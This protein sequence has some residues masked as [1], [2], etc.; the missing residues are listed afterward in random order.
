MLRLVSRGRF[1][2]ASIAGQRLGRRVQPNQERRCD[3]SANHAPGAIKPPSRRHWPKG[4]AILH[5]D[6]DILVVDKAS[7][8][9]TVSPD[10]P[11]ERT[12]HFLL[13]DYVRKGN[14]KSKNRVWIVH[15]LDKDTSGVLVF[16]K[17]EEAKR[18]LQDEWQSFT[19]T[20]YA[21]V[22]GVPA[23]KEGVVRSYLAENRVFVVYSVDNPADGKLAVT[24]YKVV[25][26]A[27]ERSLLEIELE[28]G[29]KNQIRVHC[30][31][32]GCPVVGDKKYGAR[33]AG[34]HRLALHAA[35]LTLVHPFTK[36]WMTFEAPLPD[37][38]RN[39]LRGRTG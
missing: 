16:A 18:F 39:L 1:D 9:L 35:R 5:E 14:P 17:S 11:S 30:A 25:R 7:R 12:A 28:T 24:R 19:K 37:D 2:S 23:N 32:M 27:S 13:N 15:R 8:L 38:F 36:A 20:Y 10:A 34:S 6:R 29:R 26:E 33:K 3:I 4:L 31:E 21:V 22:H